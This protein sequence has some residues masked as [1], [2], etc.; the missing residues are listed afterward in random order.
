MIKATVL[1]GSKTAAT[2]LPCDKYDL[3]EALQSI[4]IRESAKR[5]LLERD[6]DTAIR[7]LES[8]A[9][10]GN[11]YAEQLLHMVKNNR[12]WTAALGSLRLI[13]HL[14]R[15]MQNRLDDE[16]REKNGIAIDRKLR[17]QIAEKKE[18]HGIR[19]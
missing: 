1:S 7:Y 12:N 6:Y 3:Y 4:G 8:S 16:L 10:H 18:A 2:E 5:I 15:L 17:R 19:Q 14:A 11:P 13:Q 9:S